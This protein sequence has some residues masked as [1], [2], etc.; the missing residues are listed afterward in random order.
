MHIGDNLRR[1]R[2]SMDLNQSQLEEASGVSRSQISRIESGKQQNPEIKTLVALSTAL[3]T[4]LEEL[5]FGDRNPNEIKYLLQTLDEMEPEEKEFVKR[6]IKT[7]VISSQ[8]KRL[9]S[10]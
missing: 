3:G 4:S 2:T 10:T 7:C 1:I 6:L 9:E 8:T 5:V